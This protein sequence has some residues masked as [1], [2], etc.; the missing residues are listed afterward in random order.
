M[1]SNTQKLNCSVFLLALSLLHMETNEAKIPVSWKMKTP[2]NKSPSSGIRNPSSSSLTSLN[3]CCL[4]LPG[5][6]G[7]SW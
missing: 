5:K 2:K 6:L 1:I 4:N 7:F 3:F